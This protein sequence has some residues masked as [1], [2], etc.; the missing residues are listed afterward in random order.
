M[1]GK[2][3]GREADRA[4][5]AAARR[6]GSP[7]YGGALLIVT[8]AYTLFEQIGVLLIGAIIGTNAVGDLRGAD[9]AHHCSS[10]TAGRRSPSASAPRLARRRRRGAGRRARSRVATRYL[11]IL[12]GALLAPVLVWAPADRGRRARSRATR[13]PS[14]SCGRSRRSCSCSASAPSSRSPSTTWARRSSASGSRS[15]RSS[16]CTA[17]D[18]VLLPT[19]GVVGAA[20]GM[21]VAFTRLRARALLDLQARVRLLARAPRAHAGAL[22]ARGR[23]DGGR[24]RALRDVLALVGAVARRRSPAGTLAYLLALI[25]TREIS[26]AEIAGVANLVSSRLKRPEPVPERKS[27]WVGVRASRL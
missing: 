9:A 15:G 10:A 19:I 25:V 21:D 2:V 24:A 18:L 7:G 20:I 11:V 14:R 26:R 17:I 27:G 13:T 12:Q 1:I 8:I 6:A 23:R 5:R 3:L 4:L 16:L 22:P